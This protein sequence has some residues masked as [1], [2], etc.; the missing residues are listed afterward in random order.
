MHSI[1]IDTVRFYKKYDRVTANT[2]I[3]PCISPPDK[4]GRR[5]FYGHM[6]LENKEYNNQYSI[7][8][9]VAREASATDDNVTLAT[10]GDIL[11][12]IER[13]EAKTGLSIRDAMIS[14]LD[15]AMTFH[16]KYPVSSYIPLVTPVGSYFVRNEGDGRYL[17]TKSDQLELVLY[18]KVREMIDNE[19]RIPREWDNGHIARFELRCKKRISRYLKAPREITILTIDDLVHGN[20]FPAAIGM[21]DWQ[22]R[23]LLRLNDKNKGARADIEKSLLYDRL[24]FMREYNPNEFDDMWKR[25]ITDVGDDPDARK[26]VERADRELLRPYRQE[27]KNVLS[28]ACGEMS[29]RYR[30]EVEAAPD[31]KRMR[32]QLAGR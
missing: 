15:V 1:G 25:S 21:F 5:W 20:I 17:K 26:Y 14:R 10:L 9:S 32:E 8:F 16:S 2:L 11:R 28:T 19:K 13:F 30:F 23:R 6:I 24:R 18:D 31:V 3:R 12:A 29:A 27:V 7:E 22:M 4:K